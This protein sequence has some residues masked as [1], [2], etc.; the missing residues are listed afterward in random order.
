MISERALERRLRVAAALVMG[1]LVVELGS[2]FWR[3]PTAFICFFVA[4]GLLF[5]A[6]ILSYL[7]LVLAKGG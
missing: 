4:G 7:S 6:G 1:G 3:H 2:L 5:A